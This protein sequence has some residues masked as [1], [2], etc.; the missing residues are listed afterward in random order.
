MGLR[1][2][3][4]KIDPHSNSPDDPDDPNIATSLFISFTTSLA[5]AIVDGVEISYPSEIGSAR[6]R[7][8]VHQWK[9]VASWL[10]RVL[11]K[12]LKIVL[13]RLEP[14][15]AG[16]V[17]PLLSQQSPAV[18][19]AFIREVE[20]LARELVLGARHGEKD[21]EQWM[22]PD[23]A[24]QQ[25]IQLFDVVW[26]ITEGQRTNLPLETQLEM[27]DGILIKEFSTPKKARTFLVCKIIRFLSWYPA[28]NA[29][30]DSSGLWNQRSALLMRVEVGSS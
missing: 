9:R 15:S 12:E 20:T 8:P 4:G 28:V 21:R 6:G 5:G 3:L 18:S 27:L 23:H 29:M 17:R 2:D 14:R 19:L 22:H 26:N 1:G 24:D 30:Y 10:Q 13:D 16:A 25:R 7:G 11:P